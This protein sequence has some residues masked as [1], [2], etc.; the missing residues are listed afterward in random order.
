MGPTLGGSFRD[1]VGLGSGIYVWAIVWDRNE[2]IDIGKLSICG[3]GYL[4]R[5]Y[6]IYILKPVYVYIYIYIPL[7]SQCLLD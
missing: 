1:V 6:C 4:E 5:F 3:G 2:A 7:T